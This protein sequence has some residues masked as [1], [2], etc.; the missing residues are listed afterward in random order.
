M[1]P[2]EVREEKVL[3]EPDELEELE[4]HQ[5]LYEVFE[6]PEEEDGD[7]SVTQDEWIDLLYPE[8]ESPRFYGS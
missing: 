1:H 2:Q 3:E 8:D 7:V 6:E 5:R 4:D